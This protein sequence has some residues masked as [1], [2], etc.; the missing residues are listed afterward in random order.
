MPKAE[1]GQTNDALCSVFWCLF[2][3][4]ERIKSSPTERADKAPLTVIIAAPGDGKSR[5][6]SALAVNEDDEFGDR[7]AK[8]AAISH[9]NSNERA[10]HSHMLSDFCDNLLG[11]CGLCVTFNAGSDRDKDILAFSD[12]SVA[13]CSRMLWAHFCDSRV[14]PYPSFVAST[15]DSLQTMNIDCVNR[16]I[17]EDIG[18]QRHLVLCVDELMLVETAEDKA[19]DSVRQ[20][21]NSL[22]STLDQQPRVHIILSSLRS[23]PLLDWIA[24]TK[25]PLHE[26]HLLGVEWE[27]LESMIAG[28]ERQYWNSQDIVDA[29]TAGEV[30]ARL[31]RATGGNFRYVEC[32]DRMLS[33]EVPKLSVAFDRLWHMSMASGWRRVAAESPA[34]LPTV[35]TQCLSGK[36]YPRDEV[37]RL[38]ASGLVSAPS[39]RFM[40]P[41]TMP[42]L[43]LGML[44]RYVHE[45][46]RAFDDRICHLLHSCVRILTL[47]EMSCSAKQ[48]A[49]PFQEQIGHLLRIRL[50]LLQQEGHDKFSL[51]DLLRVSPGQIPANRLWTRNDCQHRYEL[52]R[53]SSFQFQPLDKSQLQ[54]LAKTG[55]KIG[56]IY[57]MKH[58]DFEAADLFVH[59][60][61]NEWISF[62]VRNSAIGATTIANAGDVEKC[63]RGYEKAHPY[64]LSVTSSFVYFANRKAGPKLDITTK[65]VR[66]TKKTAKEVN[67][68]HF[69][70]PA[71]QQV[72]VICREELFSLLPDVFKSCPNFVVSSIPEVICEVLVPVAEWIGCFLVQIPHPSGRA[73]DEASSATQDDAVEDDDDELSS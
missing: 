36:I 24:S 18:P 19:L 39:G 37:E 31:M 21:L 73:E 3:R 52:P 23:N 2:D 55:T 61:P 16:L 29:S 47:D 25:R 72:A 22:S 9:V 70:W 38:A 45:D 35:L 62:Q 44:N 51:S 6:L 50:L 27:K 58:D 4:F 34:T 30:A 12:P 40:A 1:G 64:L 43:S 15:H 32:V 11:A 69:V 53:T 33:R 26:V 13:L 60:P 65:V 57:M 54:Q 63:M 42:P 46:R 48:M 68:A 20:L 56:G 5:L 8:E 49:V 41:A 7:S 17:L 71:C 66:Q 28:L 10:Q 67:N 59:L 14:V